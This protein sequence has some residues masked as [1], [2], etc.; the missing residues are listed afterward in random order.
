MTG[1]KI[2]L[3]KK[4][5]HFKIKR[6]KKKIE[7]A[8]RRRF[9]YVFFVRWDVY[10]VQYTVLA[11]EVGL[12]NFW[13]N[14]LPLKKNPLK[15]RKKQRKSTTMF[16]LSSWWVEKWGCDER[17]TI[18]DGTTLNMWNNYMKR[19][20]K[21]KRWNIF[22]LVD[23]LVSMYCMLFPDA[24][25]SISKD[26]TAPTARLRIIRSVHLVLVTVEVKFSGSSFP[27]VMN[28]CH[29]NHTH[30]LS[31][32]VAVAAANEKERKEKQE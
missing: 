22:A 29:G 28:F 16:R 15:K 20:R 24:A 32:Q 12:Y 9:S 3:R 31:L 5:T 13:K 30:L 17:A 10:F 4:Y 19:E 11:R 25:D 8:A 27:C 14:K 7:G 21:K 18:G 26:G 2:R 1:G 6:E 23:S